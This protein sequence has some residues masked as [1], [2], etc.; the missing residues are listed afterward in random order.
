MKKFAAFCFTMMC[1]FAYTTWYLYDQQQNSTC[2]NIMTGLEQLA[3]D[4]ADFIKEKVDE[5]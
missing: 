3:E 5:L 4:S 1:I 2:K